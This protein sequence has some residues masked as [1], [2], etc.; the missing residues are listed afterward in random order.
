MRRWLL[1]TR[2][3]NKLTHGEVAARANIGRA[4]YTMIENG[5]RTPSVAVAKRLGDVLGIGWTLFFDKQGNETTHEEC[6]KRRRAL[7]SAG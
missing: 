2:L 5:S 7:E 6:G 1:N 3:S 4:Y